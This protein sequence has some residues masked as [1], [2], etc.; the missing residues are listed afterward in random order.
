MSAPQG[1]KWRHQPRWFLRLKW[2]VRALRNWLDGYAFSS[3]KR[4]RSCGHTTPYHYPRCIRG[5][6]RIEFE[7]GTK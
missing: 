6:S 4:C 5:V 1:I 3:I 7:R 2:R